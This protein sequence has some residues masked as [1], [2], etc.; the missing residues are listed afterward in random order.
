MGHAEERVTERLTD[1]G[2]SATN[3]GHIYTIA[4]SLA[5]KATVDTAFCI[6]TLP[7]RVN[8]AW[9]DRSNGNQV[10]AISRG[11]QLKTV[12]LRRDTQPATVENLRVDKVVFLKSRGG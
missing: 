5:R 1:A 11:G 6:I 10:W 3:I 9:G 8:P 12:M 4:Q 2:W 7:E